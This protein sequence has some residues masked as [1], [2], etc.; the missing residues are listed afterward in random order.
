[1]LSA[2]DMSRGQSPGHVQDGHDRGQSLVVMTQDSK[3]C[4]TSSNAELGRPEILDYV[5]GA[6][7]KGHFT[8]VDAGIFLRPDPKFLGD[9]NFCA[10]LTQGLKTLARTSV[11]AHLPR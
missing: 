5:S 1:V 11:R 10:Y 7:V 4:A 6:L 8:Y 2:K 3:A 9:V